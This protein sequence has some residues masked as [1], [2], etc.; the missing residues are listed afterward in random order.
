MVE[1]AAIVGAS[2]GAQ[3][4]AAYDYI[5]WFLSGWVGAFLNRQGYYSAVLETAK[6]NMTEDEWG[7]WVEW[8]LA[9]GVVLRLAANMSGTPRVGFVAPAGR[10]LWLE[11]SVGEGQI[12]PWTV[13]WSIEESGAVAR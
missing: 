12:G 3:L 7:F 4:D 10:R 6:A 1:D 13:L 5:N 9:R 2:D 8:R 11:G